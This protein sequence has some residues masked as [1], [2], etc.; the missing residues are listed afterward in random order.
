[1][2]NAETR[3]LLNNTSFIILH[4]LARMDQL[5]FAELLS[6]SDSQLTYI[7]NNSPGH[8]LIYT[9][10]SILPFANEFPEETE[11]YKLISTSKSKD[12]LRR[13]L[14]QYS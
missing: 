14:E 8:G 6:I 10:K 3:A 4:S 1:M 11:L 13:R 7:D 12:E 5:N 9:G 2:R